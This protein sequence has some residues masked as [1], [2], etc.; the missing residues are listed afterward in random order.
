M[1]KGLRA[2]TSLSDTIYDFDQP[3]AT[4]ICL[5]DATSHSRE[6]QS[7]NLSLCHNLKRPQE[8]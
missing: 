8:K 6:A 4:K 2:E 1:V 5:P 3:K 7:V